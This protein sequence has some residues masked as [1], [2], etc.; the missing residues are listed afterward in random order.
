MKLTVLSV[1]YPLAAVSVD[2][3]GGA[4][5]VLVVLDRALVARGHESLVVACEGSSVAGTLLP[6]PPPSGELDDAAR[7][8]AHEHV[9]QAIRY[10]CRS[11]K[12]DLIHMHGIDF[13]AYL[14]EV[15]VPV[16]ATLHLPPDWY[17]ADVFRTQRSKTYLHC[18]SES[19]R[20]RCPPSPSLLPTIENGVELQRFRRRLRKMKFVLSLGRVC[21]EKGYHLALDAAAMAGV[22]YLIGGEVF[23]YA[24]HE[25]YYRKELAPRL[26]GRSRRFLGPLGMRR[27]RRLMTA[28]SALLVPSLAPETSSL[29][30][31]EAFACGTPVIAFASGALADIVEHGKTGYLVRNAQEMAGAIQR[32]HEIKPADCRSAA[33]L[34]FPIQRMIE[35]YLQTYS[36]ICSR[37]EE[38]LPYPWVNSKEHFGI[39]FPPQSSL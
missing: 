25:E 1:G 6:I 39:T 15:D 38:R 28:A 36:T 23:R 10:A 27:K 2:A 37:G 12:V 5:Q 34:R 17:P 24:C 30:A 22:D 11:R 16:L 13:P 7:S 35:R 14:P 19:Q 31:M 4:E 26:N 9:R 18:V 8:A 3:V 32:V 33:E 20:R 21:P 29:V